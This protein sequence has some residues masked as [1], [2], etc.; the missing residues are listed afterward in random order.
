MP[1]NI[2]NNE[3]NKGTRK[4]WIDANEFFQRHDNAEETAVF[5]QMKNL[6]K[7]ANYRKQR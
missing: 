2:G 5:Q 3:N 7:K 4:K 1:K 6:M